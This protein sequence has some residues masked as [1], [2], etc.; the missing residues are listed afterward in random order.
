MELPRSRPRSSRRAHILL[1]IT[2]FCTPNQ[3]NVKCRS[4]IILAAERA[5]S[6]MIGGANGGLSWKQGFNLGRRT[7]PSPPTA[8]RVNHYRPP[9][10]K[11]SQFASAFSALSSMSWSAICLTAA[12]R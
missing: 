12:F 6:D 3:W 9:L 5:L 8:I 11:P 7:R 10:R 2:S 1:Q 4:S